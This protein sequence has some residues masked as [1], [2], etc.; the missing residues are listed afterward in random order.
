[1]FAQWQVD[2]LLVSAAIVAY[3]SYWSG[4]NRGKREGYV[5]GRSIMRVTNER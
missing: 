1:M 3:M 2:L 5:A 4:Y